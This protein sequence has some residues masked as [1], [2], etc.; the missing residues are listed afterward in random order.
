VHRAKRPVPAL[1]APLSPVATGR[2]AG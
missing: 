2:V 1:D